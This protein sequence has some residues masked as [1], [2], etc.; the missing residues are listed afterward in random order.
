MAIEVEGI[1]D[2]ELDLDVDISEEKERISLTNKEAEQYLPMIKAIS[3]NIVAAGKLPPGMFYDDLVSYGYEGLIKAYQNYTDDKGAQFQT[4][5][6]YR[7]RGEIL[8][9]IRK[10][11]KY[12]NPVSY[13]YMQNKMKDK[14]SEVVD[15]TIKSDEKLSSVEIEAKKTRAKD[16]IAN[17]AVVYLLSLDNEEFKKQAIG[18]HDIS[19]DAIEK[20]EYTKERQMLW[21]EIATLTEQEK[22]F[23]HLFYEKELSQKDIA[24]RIGLSKSK[25]SRMH[26]ALLN[27]LRIR[28]KR[29][30]DV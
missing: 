19:N 12:R 20:V 10:E 29:K 13:K 27:K 17:S 26:V 21:D 15:E 14:L 7:V 22:D 28:L 9:K 3:A 23:L 16:M 6:A 25:A 11:W 4:Y 30:M 18:V 24:E 5:A 1:E 8:D 2:Q